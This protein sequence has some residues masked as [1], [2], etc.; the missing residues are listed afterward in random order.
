MQTYHLP[1][2]SSLC[3]SKLKN[4][5]VQP[6]FEQV[7]LGGSSSLLGWDCAAPSTLEMALGKGKNTSN[8]TPISGAVRSYF[9]QVICPDPS[10]PTSAKESQASSGCWLVYT[11]K[12]FLSASWSQTLQYLRCSRCI[13]VHVR[14]GVCLVYLTCSLTWIMLSPCLSPGLQSASPHHN[15]F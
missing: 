11:S 12:K 10:Q 5:L 9:L 4:P 2:E 3:S 8:R 14:V 6:L 15:H 1:G 7:P 13:C